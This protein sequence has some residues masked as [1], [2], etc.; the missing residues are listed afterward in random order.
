MRTTTLRADLTVLL[1][2]AG[3]VDVDVDEAVEDEH[4]RSAAY[5]QV[6]AVVAAARRRD[7]DRAVVSVILR[8]PEELV[9]KAAVV[10]LVDRVAMRTADPAD[11]RQWATG[12]MPEVDRLTTDGHRGFLH[13]R[14]HDWTTYLTVMAGRTPAAAELAGVTDWMQRRIAE[15]STSL[16][17]L[18]M[19]TETGST[20]K[21]RNIARNRARSRAVRDA[22]SADPGCGG[23]RPGT[24]LP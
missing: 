22:L 18:A 23:P 3:I 2:G 19:L 13:R 17:V 12:L 14:V 7:D 4:V 1:A 24:S 5:R 9:S 15:E 11:F 20:K 16:P 10:E 21:T 6:I 8:D